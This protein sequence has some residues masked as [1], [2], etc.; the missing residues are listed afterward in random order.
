MYKY[1]EC[2]AQIDFIFVVWTQDIWNNNIVFPNPSNSNCVEQTCNGGVSQWKQF[3][4]TV[5]C[6]Y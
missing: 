6:S 2:V 5:R 1:Y 3:N 4:C